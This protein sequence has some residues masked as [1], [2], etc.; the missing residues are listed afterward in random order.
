MIEKAAY[1]QHS[2]EDR[3]KVFC[4]MVAVRVIGVSWSL[5]D[6]QGNEGRARFDRY[7]FPKRFANSERELDDNVTL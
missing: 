5:R 6:A 3:R 2:F 7:N 4:L 1:D